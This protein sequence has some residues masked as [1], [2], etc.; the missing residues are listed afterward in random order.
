MTNYQFKI[1]KL[2]NSGDFKDLD[3]LLQKF[4]AQFQNELENL[5][6]LKLFKCRH[7][8]LIGN[9]KQALDKLDWVLEKVK[10]LQN[11][12]IFIDAYLIRC[13][14]LHYLGNYERFAKEIKLIETTIK[15]ASQEEHYFLKRNAKLEQLKGRYYTTKGDYNNALEHLFKS[16][17]LYRKSNLNLGVATTLNV[18]AGVYWRKG[19]S[20]NA[21]EALNSAVEIFKELGNKKMLSLAFNNLG[22]M[23]N[24]VGDYD[25][26]IQN[27]KLALQMSIQNKDI[28]NQGKCLGNLGGTYLLVGELDLAEKNFL[29]SL[30]LNK[31]IG[32]KHEIAHEYSNL[33]HLA[34]SKGNFEE[35]IAY[36][37]MSI[38]TFKSISQG[39]LYLG[40]LV[41][42]I[43]A[44]IDSN[45][46]DESDKYRRDLAE[47]Y[48]QHGTFKIQFLN[49][50]TIAY[51]LKK[52][53]NEK[54][55]SKAKQIF[56]KL[57]ENSDVEFDWRMFSVLNYSDLII[58]HLKE[59]NHKSVLNEIKKLMLNVLVLAKSA[60]SFR[61]FA[62]TY[63][64][65]AQIE[66][67]ENNHD[68]ARE[69]L[70]KAESISKNKKLKLLKKIQNY[71]LKID[72]SKIT[73]K[74][75][76]AIFEDLKTELKEMILV[77]G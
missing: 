17:K 55:I 40:P 49:E 9:Y 77:R 19:E 52:Y 64:I 15:E 32:S 21:T 67:L 28:Q 68:Q 42:I 20:K 16:E 10:S 2:F 69:Y 41:G 5:I 43:I 3:T 38:E 59:T 26:A 37:K 29:E 27:F 72:Y 48:Q 12:L 23:N 47:M 25:Y 58:T 36:F 45:L 35:A 44:L 1:Q 46:K 34:N 31:Q 70:L 6:E 60:V 75:N 13:E 54:E 57:S 30:S 33:G 56:L 53:G 24:Q 11:N 62:Q 66:R 71:Y 14:A 61:I 22:I 73:F 39:P 76:D 50:I 4:E 7:E 8:V 18:R 63:L 65:L 51:Y 74:P